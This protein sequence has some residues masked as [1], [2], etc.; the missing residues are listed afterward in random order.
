[1]ISIATRGGC[2][3]RAHPGADLRFWTMFISARG[4]WG[5]SRHPGS[6]DCEG[7]TAVVRGGSPDVGNWH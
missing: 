2:R 5:I 3:R 6:G 1:M 4:S 7:S